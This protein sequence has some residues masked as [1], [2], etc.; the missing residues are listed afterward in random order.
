LQIPRAC[1][2]LPPEL[3]D[4]RATWPDPAAYDAQARRL[5]AMFTENFSALEADVPDDVK[6][7]G[8]RN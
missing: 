1:P 8:A 5:A 3:L 7:A 4:P 6:R 2:G